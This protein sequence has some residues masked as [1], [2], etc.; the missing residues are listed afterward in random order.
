MNE[1]L[2]GNTYQVQYF[3]RRRMELHP[4]QPGSPILLGLLGRTVLEMEQRITTPTGCT[5][6]VSIPPEITDALE[7]DAYLSSRLGCP[8]GSFTLNQAGEQFFERGVML[9]TNLFEEYIYVIKSDP[10]PVTYERFP[11]TWTEAEPASGG[12]TPPAG[13]IEP[14]RGFGKVWRENSGVRETLGWATTPERPANGIYISFEGGDL[15]WLTNTDYLY[16]FFF[17]MTDAGNATARPR[18][19]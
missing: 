7:S 5:D 1:R 17:E 13:L 15:Y 9:Y 4:E 2:E 10:L 18:T 14:V 11:D 8:L 12:E 19:W 3:E 6:P 16:V